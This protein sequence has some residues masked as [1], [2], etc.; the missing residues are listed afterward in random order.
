VVYIS[1]VDPYENQTILFTEWMAP[2]GAKVIFVNPR[3]SQTAAYAE[4]TGGVHLQV[5]PGTDSVL[6]N[7]IAR[8]I[9]ERGWQD[10]DF[11]A[12][13]MANRAEIE[14][15]KGQWRRLRYGMTFDEYKAFLLADDAYALDKAA[16]LT[17]VPAAKIVL[18]AKMLAKPRGKLRPKASFMLEKGNYWSFN[19][20]NS[21]SLTGL[22]L[23]RK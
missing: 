3:K 8:Y 20:P 23:I 13:R 12:R 4:R 1:G 16:E 7:A 17:H 15:E 6:N 9:V 21:A 2:G 14:A 18:A 19:L 22:E 11:I 5:W 10:S